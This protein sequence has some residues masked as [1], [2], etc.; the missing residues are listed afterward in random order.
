M[1]ELLRFFRGTHGHRISVNGTKDLGIRDTD[2]KWG[3]KDEDEQREISAMC[4]TGN[5]Y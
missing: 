3:A 5:T 1:A 2:I 4:G